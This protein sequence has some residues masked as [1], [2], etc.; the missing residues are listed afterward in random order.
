[1]CGI[2]CIYNDNYSP[3]QKEAIIIQMTAALLHR[4]PDEWGL[5]LSSELAFGHTRLS[6]VDITDGHQ[7]MENERYVIVYNGEVYNYIELGEELKASGVALMTRSDTEVVLKAFSFWGINCFK[8]FNGQF[9]GLIWDK[10][11]KNL[12]AFRDRYGVRP[13]Y[14]L[15]YKNAYFF[16]SE[17]KAFDYIPGYKRTFN[18]QNLLEH[19]LLWN[20]IGE[21][22]VFNNIT[23][24]PSGSFLVLRQNEPPSINKYYTLG[25]SQIDKPRSFNEAQEEIVSL[26]HDSIRLRL[27]SDVAVGAYLSGGI[28]SSVVTA[29]TSTICGKQFKTFSVSFEDPNYDE[30]IYQKEMV[31][32]IGS[33]H[34]SLKISYKD[35]E[36]NLLKA[37]YHIE[38]PVFRTA[39]IPLFLLSNCVKQN[40]IKVVLTGEASDEIFYGYDSFKELRLLEFW[41]KIPNS[42]LRPLLIKRLYPHLH[43][44][45]DSEQFGFMKMYYEGFLDHFDNDLVSLNIRVAN[46]KILQNYFHKDLKIDYSYS[47]LLENIQSILPNHYK[48]WSILRKNQFLE[49]NTLLSGY[50]LSSQGDRMSLANGIE[51]R[52]PFLD[53]R[54][55]ETVFSYPDNYKLKG[56]SQKHILRKAFDGFIPDSIIERPK[57]PY[58]APDLIAFINNNFISDIVSD[59]LSPVK[60]NDSGIFDTKIVT[61]FLRKNLTSNRQKIGYRDNMIMIFLLSTQ[62]SK[63]WM[64]NPPPV[65]LD[66]NRLAVRIVD[67]LQFN[68]ETV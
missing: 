20:T 8:K 39:P 18:Y 50:L 16:A 41:S 59:F 54:L 9:A 38:R 1:M 49:M 14:M 57:L 61:N 51:G 7:P 35:I 33:E 42:H 26:L 19:G 3:E 24:V 47:L 63:F 64:D 2:A 36:S 46:N 52:Y 27:R 37:I 43:H 5:Y 29:L 23:S 31:D 48:E 13:L 45:S 65:N 6:I 67:N 15:S 58:Q 60:L 32:K 12:I 53:H 22:T 11:D 28:D 56:F 68:N 66:E 40:N 21:K 34:S 30:S 44:Y 4:G 55:V 17:T 62:I 10:Y 25:E